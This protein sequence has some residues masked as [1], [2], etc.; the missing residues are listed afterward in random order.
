MSGFFSFLRSLFGREPKAETVPASDADCGTEHGC[1]EPV[2]CEPPA[3]ECKAETV[4]IESKDR[5][6][7]MTDVLKKIN[8]A[9]DALDT[10][11][12]GEDPG[13]APANT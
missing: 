4:V 12:N 7:R 6:A 3:L 2:G 11:L 10:H 13:A 1:G 5:R 9:S 8:R